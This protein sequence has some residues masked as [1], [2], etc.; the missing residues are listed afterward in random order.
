M[1]LPMSS[2]GVGACSPRE[3]PDHLVAHDREKVVELP[4]PTLT[5]DTMAA[6]LIWCDDPQF[7]KC[8]MDGFCAKG[9]TLMVWRMRFLCV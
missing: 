6:I 7:W 8:A 9:G 4:S 3:Y 2:S 5:C 1:R